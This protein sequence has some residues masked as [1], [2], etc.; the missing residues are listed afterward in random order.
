MKSTPVS[1]LSDR[2]LR[3]MGTPLARL[4]RLCCGI[5]F[6]GIGLSVVP[7]FLTCNIGFRAGGSGRTHWFHSY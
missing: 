5:E 7:G 3:A 1:R 2:V 6:R 4:A